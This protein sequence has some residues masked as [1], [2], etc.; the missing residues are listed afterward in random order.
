MS[1]FD[2]RYFLYPNGD[3]VICRIPSIEYEKHLLT[4]K[5]RKKSRFF[6]LSYQKYRLL[7]SAAS[8]MS[9][10]AE[11]KLIFLTF[12]FND[13]LKIKEVM[14]NQIW[15]RF[16][17]N[18]KKT[19]GCKNYV[20]VLE[21]HKSGTPHYHFI[22]D[23]PY[24]PIVEINKAWI[25]AITSSVGNDYDFV[26]GSVRL[27]EDTDSVV[28]NTSRAVRYLCKYFSKGLGVRYATKCYFISRDLRE[29]SRFREITAEQYEQIET[30]LNP[31]KSR[32]FEHCRVVC[33]NDMDIEFFW[34]NI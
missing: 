12:T 25:A 11:N 21:Y 17:K 5:E 13:K 6:Q 1:L 10:T 9:K 31:V 2:N 27:P 28:D 15:N 4:D 34:H 33:Y 3:V 16:I 8:I 18:F 19:Y 23:F 20:G 22:A 32:K 29:K 26:L 7:A 30:N 14:A 24:S